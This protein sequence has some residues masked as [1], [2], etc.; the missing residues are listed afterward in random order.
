MGRQTIE[1]KERIP[2]IFITYKV[3]RKIPGGKYRG[4][5]YDLIPEGE[6]VVLDVFNDEIQGRKSIFDGDT[7]IKVNPTETLNESKQ[8][9]NPELKEGDFIRIYDV[10]KDSPLI[11]QKGYTD[12]DRY[13]M[14]GGDSVPEIFKVYVVMLVTKYKTTQFGKEGEKM[15]VLM[16]PDMNPSRP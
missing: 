11:S 13:M 8:E 14:Y 9:F 2:E 15:Y 3:V 16:G 4:V 12:Q 5:R 10:D 1:G 7:W 6:G